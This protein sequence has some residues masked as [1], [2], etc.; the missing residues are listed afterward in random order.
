MPK[1]LLATTNP[2]KLR[3]LRALFALPGLVL[4]DP[5]QIALRLDVE[6]TGSTYLE[7]ARLKAL[8][9][10]GACGLWTVADDTGLEVDALRG[11]PGLLSA[12]AGPNDGLRRLALL[13]S[14]RTHPRPWQAQFRCGLVLA[15]PLGSVDEAEGTVAGEVVPE[16]R[17]NN[18]FGY[19][20]IFLV[21]GTGK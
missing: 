19:D 7:N 15:G 2:G 4:T 14:L 13:R 9:H 12:R 18:G 10:A 1:L 17:G 5:D 6:E 8:A 21:E 16:A 3:E 11:A 20:P